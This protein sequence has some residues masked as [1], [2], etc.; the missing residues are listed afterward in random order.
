MKNATEVRLGKRASES[1][2]EYLGWAMNGG[3]F[4]YGEVHL[5]NSTGWHFKID[6]S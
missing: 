2:K 5:Q 1:G 3:N 6:N 4:K